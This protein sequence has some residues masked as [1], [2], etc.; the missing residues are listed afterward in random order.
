[1]TTESKSYRVAE[2]WHNLY[3]DFEL[4]PLPRQLESEPIDEYID[5][6]YN[7]YESGPTLIIQDAICR[8]KMNLYRSIAQRIK[9]RVFSLRL[10]SGMKIDQLLALEEFADICDIVKEEILPAWDLTEFVDF[11]TKMVRAIMTKRQMLGLCEKSKKKR[12][13]NPDPSFYNRQKISYSVK[14]QLRMRPKDTFL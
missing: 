1:M 4:L 14:Q 13:Q 7:R 12:E 10:N 8:R 5:F 11:F 6:C 3:T 2:I 9:I